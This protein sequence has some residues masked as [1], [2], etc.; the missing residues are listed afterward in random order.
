MVS[1]FFCAA[2]REC[3]D[4]CAK[5]E[6]CGR[7]KNI[8]CN[9]SQSRRKVFSAFSDGAFVK[10]S[11]ERWHVLYISFCRRPM[12]INAAAVFRFPTA[13]AACR[14]RRRYR[15]RRR[16]LRKQQIDHYVLLLPHCGASASAV[17]LRPTGLDF[18][19]FK[20]STIRTPPLRRLTKSA[21]SEEH[22]VA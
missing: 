8:L 21:V 2:F 14:R 12:P 22:F 18:M 6:E 10:T 11:E 17:F 4:F 1:A 7:E 5:Q 9:Y 13:A 3:W 16:R 15:S 20:S 19:F